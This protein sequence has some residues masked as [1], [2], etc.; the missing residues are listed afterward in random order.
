MYLKGML[1]LPNLWLTLKTV[2]ILVQSRPEVCRHWLIIFGIGRRLYHHGN[3]QIMWVRLSGIIVGI[4]EYPG[5]T[6][7]TLD[8]SS[9]MCIECTALS[10]KPNVSTK[11]AVS[12]KPDPVKKEE[13]R[14]G[15]TVAKPKIPWENMDVGVAVIIKGGVSSFRSQKQVAIVKVEVLK[16]TDQ[17]V[18]FWN[19]A[20]GFRQNVLS[21]PWVVTK[22]E[23]DKCMREASGKRSHSTRKERTEEKIERKAVNDENRNPNTQRE[24]GDYEARKRRKEREK[25]EKMDSDIKNRKKSDKDGPKPNRYSSLVIAARRRPA[26]K[27]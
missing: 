27:A 5:R 12:Q 21:V 25:R 2:G 23:E 24:Q 26:L 22:K 13:K 11:P 14:T 8:D 9:G 6:I 18:N 17:E 3:H 10:P 15:P 7:I 19:N 16:S 1:S 20:L 4:D